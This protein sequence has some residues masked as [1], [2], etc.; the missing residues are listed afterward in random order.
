LVEGRYGY[1]E[2]VGF[3]DAIYAFEEERKTTTFAGLR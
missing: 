3:E 2:L 1:K